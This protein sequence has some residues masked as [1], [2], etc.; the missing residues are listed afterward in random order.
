MIPEKYPSTV[1][2]VGETIDGRLSAGSR[3][4]G[5]QARRLAERFDAEPVGVLTG[6]DIEPVA[7]S[8]SKSAGMPVIVLDHAQCRYPNPPLT[9]SGVGAL[10]Y[11]CSPLAVC[12]PHTMRACQAA[13]TL[14]WRIKAPCITAVD[15]L[16]VESN[17]VV[18]KRAVFGGKL[19]ETVTTGNTP[20]VL[21]IMP[22]LFSRS[23]SP[24][25]PDHSPSVGTRLLADTNHRFIPQGMNR[26]AHTDQALERA[27]V[28][29]A[30]GRGLKGPE[31][32]GLLDMA[33]GMFK[34][35]AVGGSRGACDLGWLPYALQIGETG[36]TVSPALYL[37]CGISGAPQHLA[38]MR[39]SRTVVA[40]NTDPKAAICNLAHFAVIDDLTVFL[41]VLRERYDRMRDKGDGV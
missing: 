21:T 27:Q 20:M 32:A 16:L 3:D 40:V 1:L 26:R 41:P 22:G 4:L 39:E 9:A 33:V 10:V 36:R 11:E 30:A 12:F 31:H 37:A 14:A 25:V 6:H 15:A 23:A 7:R 19:S 8:W 34:H 29:V 38:G 24:D 13:A 18:L 5:K 2:V 17:Q 35:A 28:I